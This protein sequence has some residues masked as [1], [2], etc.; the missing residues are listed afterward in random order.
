MYMEDY[1]MFWMS[2]FYGKWVDNND[3]FRAE[4]DF[5]LVILIEL[6]IQLSFSY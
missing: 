5:N 1:C 3:G 6:H 4:S 2:V